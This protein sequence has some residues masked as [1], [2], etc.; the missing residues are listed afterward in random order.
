VSQKRNLLY[1]RQLPDP[2]FPA[3][4]TATVLAGLWSLMSGTVALSALTALGVFGA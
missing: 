4:L 1:G 2:R 3:V